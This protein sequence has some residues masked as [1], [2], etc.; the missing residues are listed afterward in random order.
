MARCKVG[1]GVTVNL[2]N[3]EFFRADV[4]FEEDAPDNSQEEKD[5][6]FERL[7]VEA[8][9]RLEEIILSE[10]ENILRLL[11]A[12]KEEWQSRVKD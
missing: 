2:G 5:A 10:G 12:V 7:R 1:L 11:P 3:Y 9:T 6:C 4:G 8:R